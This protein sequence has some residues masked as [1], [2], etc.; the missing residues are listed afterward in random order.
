MKVVSGGITAPKGY[1]A[2]GIHCGIKYKNKDLALIY[3]KVPSLACGV[4][5]QNRV[6]GAP[7]KITKDHLKNNKAQAVV[8]NSGNA[9]CCTGKRG[10]DDARKVCQV[11]AKGLDISLRDVLTASTGI[12]GKRLPVEKIKKASAALINKLSAKGS[13]QAAQAIMTTDT[14]PKQISVQLMIGKTKVRIGGVAKGAG[15]IQPQLATMLGFITTDAAIDKTRLK[16]ALKAAVDNSFNLITVE[17]DTSTN[18]MV[19]VLANGLAGNKSMSAQDL[20][21]FQK[22]LNFVCLSLAK[23]IVQDGEGATK[24][25]EVYVEGAKNIA[26]A[27]RIAFKVA[28]S[29]LVKTAIFGENPNWGRIAAS[30][31]MADKDVEQKNLSIYLGG[32]KVLEKGAALKINQQRLKKIFKKKDIQIRVG[33]GLGKYAARVFTCDLSNEYVKINAE[34]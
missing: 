15:M 9:N 6:V 8:I 3:S 18:D 14:K 23:M 5:T 28:N 16:K 4:F 25:V 11:I 21:V 31:G 32:I 10:L 19:L 24:F 30:T 17:G 29:P 13:T 33:L 27:E 1:L 22:G 34:Y 2:S 26:Q 12:I 20:K 7:L